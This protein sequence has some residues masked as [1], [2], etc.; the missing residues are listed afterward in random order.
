MKPYVEEMR[1]HL[2]PM[3]RGSYSREKVRP[4]SCNALARL[5]ARQRR[6][7]DAVSKERGYR[8]FQAWYLSR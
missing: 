6:Q 2:L 3:I 8:P 7:V 5:T 4:P 1:E